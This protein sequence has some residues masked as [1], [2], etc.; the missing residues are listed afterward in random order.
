MLTIEDVER[1]VPEIFGDIKH[2]KIRRYKEIL[3]YLPDGSSAPIYQ[4]GVTIEFAFLND[5]DSF[6]VSSDYPNGPVHGAGDGLCHMKH[7]KL[8]DESELRQFLVN[9]HASLKRDTTIRLTSMLTAILG[10][11]IRVVSENAQLEAMSADR[12]IGRIMERDGSVPMRDVLDRFVKEVRRR[13][14]KPDTDPD[15]SATK[16]DS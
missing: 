4:W 1:L 16:T 14:E 2:Y 15:P 10:P 13:R 11:K 9:C 3:R 5:T 8:K 7:Q 6:E 12:F